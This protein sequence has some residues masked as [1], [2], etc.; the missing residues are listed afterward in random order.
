MTVAGNNHSNRHHV[1]G[2]TEPSLPCGRWQSY[3][4]GAT[5]NNADALRLKQLRQVKKQPS[6][7]S[8]RRPCLCPGESVTSPANS[9]IIAYQRTPG[10]FTILYHPRPT[11]PSATGDSMQEDLISAASSVWQMPL[12]Q[13]AGTTIYFSQLMI[14]LAVI[15]IGFMLVRYVATTLARR[16]HAGPHISAQQAHV[17]RKLVA[18]LGYLAITLIALPIAGIPIT[19]F[20]VLGGALAIGVGFGAQNLLNNLISGI[21]LL[22]E[23]PI[24]IGDVVELETDKGRVEDIG[25][26]CV[27]IRRFDGVHVLVPNSYFPSN[28]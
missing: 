9:L 19:V 13:A 11:P 27:R 14:A 1:L 23:R 4:P 6:L 15:I 8:W 2:I 17:I 25:N 20:A 22:V 21:I 24:K 5:F 12:Y 10:R 28:G 7:R 18:Y 16:V 26:R 3:S